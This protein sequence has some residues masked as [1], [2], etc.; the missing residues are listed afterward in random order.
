MAGMTIGFEGDDFSEFDTAPVGTSYDTNED[1][2]YIGTYGLEIDM[3][4][5]ITTAGTESTALSGSFT[6]LRT[7]AWINIGDLSLTTSK[8]TL[9]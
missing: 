9:F 7:G 6:Q 2:A 1:A 4:G 5:T 3:A 8:T